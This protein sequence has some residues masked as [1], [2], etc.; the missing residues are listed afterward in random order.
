MSEVPRWLGHLVS[1]ALV[2]LALVIPA[3]VSLA[4]FDDRASHLISKEEPRHPVS[5]TNFSHLYQ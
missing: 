5:E 3:L 1:L 2:S 4:P